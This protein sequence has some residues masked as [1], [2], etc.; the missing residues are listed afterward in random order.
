MQLGYSR[1][2]RRPRYYWLLPFFSYVDARSNTSGNP[3][4]NPEYSDS[5]ELGYLKNWTK[6]SLLSN[7]YYRY[8]INNMDWLTFSD[9][10]GVTRRMP[11]NLGDKNSFGIE[12]SGSHEIIKWWNVSGSF[13]FFREMRDGSFQGRDFDVDTYVWSTR[14]NTKWTIKK[15]VN[16]QASGNYRAPKQSA[17]GEDLARYSIDAGLSFDLLKGNGT[18]AFNVKDVLNSRKRQKTSQG[19]NFVSEYE[20]QWRSRFFRVSFTYRINQKKKRGGNRN[21]D[22]FGGG[23]G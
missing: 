7:I 1:R 2:I 14:L 22:D 3:N 16:L 4:L 19:P 17:Q 20:F 8:T 10:E 13:N 5:Y 12:F 15:K 18:M 23:E 9:A 11:Q 6:S 21:Y